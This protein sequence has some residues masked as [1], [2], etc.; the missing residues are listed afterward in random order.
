[1]RWCQR[2]VPTAVKHSESATGRSCCSHNSAWNQPN[3]TLPLRPALHTLTS[4]FPAATSKH[5]GATTPADNKTLGL[6]PRLAQNGQG[7]DSGLVP[8]PSCLHIQVFERCR[9]SVL[10]TQEFHSSTTLINYVAYFT[11]LFPPQWI[12]QSFPMYWKT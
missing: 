6:G 1:M 2:R 11:P 3:N 12:P 9:F 7:L 8:P 4:S 10:T 5:T